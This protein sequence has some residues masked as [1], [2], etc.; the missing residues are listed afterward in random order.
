MINHIFVEIY[1]DFFFIVS[2]HILN[3]LKKI[4]YLTSIICI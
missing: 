3:S 1:I 2:N 4:I